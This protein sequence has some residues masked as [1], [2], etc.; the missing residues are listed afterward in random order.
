MDG[1]THS[2]RRT[3][4]VIPVD[5]DGRVLLLR[6][7]DIGGREHWFTI[8]GAIEA[9]ETPAQAASRELREETGIRLAPEDL[10]TACYVG[11]HAFR[12]RG[13][14]FAG[15]ATVFAIPVD[16]GTSLSFDGAEADEVIVGSRWFK[17]DALATEPDSRPPL[18]VLLRAAAAHVAAL[19]GDV[20]SPP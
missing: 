4:R 3:A 6:G 9:G 17:P 5:P 16:P 20:G 8:G 10:G 2:V 12:Y 1:A 11:P 13:S 19:A 18:R 15:E 14:L 7:E